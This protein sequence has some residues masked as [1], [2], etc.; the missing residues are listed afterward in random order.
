MSHDISGAS[1]VTASGSYFSRHWR[2]ALSLGQSYWVN[3]VLIAILCRIIWFAGITAI[4]ISMPGE[5]GQA[6][7]A[8][9]LLAVMVAIYIWQVVGVWRSAGHHVERGGKKFWAIVA[10]ISCGLGVLMAAATVLESL[11][12]IAQV[13][14]GGYQ[15]YPK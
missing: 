9:I 11:S 5:P 1:Q 2:G 8:L 15:I 7:P 3:G 10:R 14:Q 6:L 4:G 12:V 13:M